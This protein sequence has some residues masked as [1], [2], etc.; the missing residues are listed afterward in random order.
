MTSTAST[1]AGLGE[2]R[3][4]LTV[5]RGV[6]VSVG[7]IVG[8]GLLVLPGLAYAN[9]GAGA[10]FGWALAA[11]VVVPLLF[12][13][14]QLGAQHPNAGGVVGFVR[15]AFGRAGAAPIA[16]TLLG[17]CAFGG[18]AMAISGGNYVAALFGHAGIVV[19]AA[20][21][22]VML[23]GW[24]NALGSQL[25]GS[26]QTVLTA[27]LVLLVAAVAA[28][29]FLRPGFE[30][31]GVVAVPDSWTTLLPVVGLV[32]FAFTGWELVASTTEEYRNPRRDLP[33]VVGLTFLLVVVLYLGVATA[34]QISLQPTDPRLQQAPLAAVLGQ[35]LGDA[36]GATAAA[37]GTLVLFGT[38]MGGMWA[39]SRIVFATARE[40]LLPAR[41]TRVSARTGAPV[42]AVI[43]SGALFVGVI[44]LHGLGLVA[45]NTVFQL[46]AVNFVVGYASSVLAY[47]RL[48]R[49]WWQ[50]A[51][52][53]LAMA[54]I[55]VVLA[56]FG[57]LLWYPAALLVGG[58][59]AHRRTAA[60]PRSSASF[61]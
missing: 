11:G 17:A 15:A 49:R 13:F 53:V 26:L 28:V 43:V 23:T 39:T 34:V 8:S 4:T 27:V 19:L 16:F 22:Y 40:A 21:G 33:L 6:G 35:V 9:A 55:L 18:A 25:A 5:T 57:W 45:L 59:F 7:M 12:V 51:L 10:V 32:F 29:P 47:G 44:V 61:G 3:K 52:A 50:R 42:A 31:H 46:S 1:P 20:L 48:F 58:Y 30:P 60:R 14:A 54:P 2:L 41:L 36:A 24:L 37:L 38:L 56:G